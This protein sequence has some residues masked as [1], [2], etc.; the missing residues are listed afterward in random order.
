MSNEPA[1][2]TLEDIGQPE[3]PPPA[4]AKAQKELEKFSLPQLKKLRY[5]QETE[6][7]RR[8]ET[9]RTTVAAAILFV[10]GAWLACVFALLAWLGHGE[11]RL[12]D[13]VLIALLTTTTINVIGLLY[14]VVRYLFP[15]PLPRRRSIRRTRRTRKGT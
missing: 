1:K 6:R 2:P 3:L 15:R 10:V 8:E 7:L 4:D 13:A 5:R 12:S 14:T 9:L 11:A